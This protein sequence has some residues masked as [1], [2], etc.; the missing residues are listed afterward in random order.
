MKK[1]ITILIVTLAL[2]TAGCAGIG[3]SPTKTVE[4]FASE[5]SQ[6]NY[7]TCYDMMS[8]AYKE[9]TSLSDFV[10]IC[11]DVN[12]DKY[13]FIEVTNEYVNENTAVVDVLVNE[14]SVAI[15][16]SLENFIEVEPEYNEVTK[17]LDLVKQ[18]DEWKITEFPYAL[19]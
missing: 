1:Q 6:E 17:E 15:K 11:K 5:Y 14:S 13:E 7:D 12:P 16:F 18:E 8:T 4:N 3:S 2:L 9:E 19:T 10:D